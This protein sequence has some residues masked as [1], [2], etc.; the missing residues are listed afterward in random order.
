MHHERELFELAAQ[1]LLA[2]PDA[3]DERL[4][5]LVVELD[6]ELVPALPAPLRQRPG[7]GRLVRTYLA[8]GLLDRLDELSSRPAPH[9]QHEHGVG[10]ERGQRRLQ[11]AY[12]RGLPGADVVDE[13]V[14]RGGIEAHGGE[15]GDDLVWLRYARVERLEASGPALLFGPASDAGPPRVDLGVVVAGDEIRGL[16]A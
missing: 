13:Q 3:G 1:P 12:V 4:R 2:R 6:A 14:A 10:R 7:L 5:G 16:Q 9:D 15:R 11:R 8:A